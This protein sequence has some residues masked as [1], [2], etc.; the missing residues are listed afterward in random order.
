M[1]GKRF[2]GSKRNQKG[3]QSAKGSTC[4]GDVVELARYLSSHSIRCDRYGGIFADT[5]R[6]RLPPVR[7]I[8]KCPKQLLESDSICKMYRARSA[9]TI[10]F[11]CK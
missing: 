6:D 2:I 3:G 8:E 7:V 1:D 9:F 10:W 11:V 4:I 5:A